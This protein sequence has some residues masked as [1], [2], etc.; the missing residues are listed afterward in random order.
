MAISR[1][2][3]WTK[4]S[5]TFCVRLVLIDLVVFLGWVGYALLFGGEFVTRRKKVG[6]GYVGFHPWSLTSL[7]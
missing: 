3:Q 1:R 6:F 5:G 2:E 4:M 7:T